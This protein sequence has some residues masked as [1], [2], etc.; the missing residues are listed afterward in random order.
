M[1]AESLYI[2]L[3]SGTSM[4]AVDG[5]LVDFAHQPPKLI[6]THKQLLPEDLRKELIEL[7]LPGFN[8]IN[9]LGKLD[10]RVGQLFAE[11]TKNLLNKAN[12]SAKQICAIGSHGQTVR[13]KPDGEYPFTLQIGD[14]NLIATET[15]ITTVADFRRRDMANNGQGAP[16]TPAFHAYVFRDATED[17]IILNLGGIANITWLPADN[18]L[19][20]LG[21]DTGP[22]NLLLDA[23]I[24]QQCRKPFDDDGRWGAT[25]K[26][27]PELLT[28][29]LADPYFQ[30]A[31][32][33]ST[34]R[35]LF[36]LAWLEKNLLT[37]K[38]ITPADVQATLCELTARSVFHA[39]NQLGLTRGKILV[40]GGGIRNQHLMQC[41]TQHSSHFTLHSTKEFG[42][43]PEWVEAMTFAWFAQQTL[44]QKPSNIPSVT[45]A[46]RP[47]ILGGVYF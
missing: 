30:Q 7:C 37:Q 18:T 43:P 22:A 40:C 5:V 41:L 45:G 25:G 36:N 31:P 10:V 33:K 17:R 8:E 19:P 28:Q 11:T 13:H 38:K 9:R 27:N 29:L 16:L 32:P 26:V 6:A 34:G 20:V 39:I 23:W 12:I 14:P 42:I 3:M 1:Q 24:Y 46:T 4:D 44:A 21:F 15:G 47:V 35:E 2:G